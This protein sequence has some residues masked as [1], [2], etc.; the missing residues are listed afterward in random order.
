M[1]RLDATFEGLKL[2]TLDHLSDDILD[3]E[4][5]DH[6]EY[7]D[8]QIYV[9]EGNDHGGVAFVND[10]TS[11]DHGKIL[12][13]GIQPRED[14]PNEREA[15]F[16]HASRCHHITWDSYVDGDI[17]NEVSGRHVGES[18]LT[19]VF[20]PLEAA[21]MAIWAQKNI[22]FRYSAPLH[23]VEPPETWGQEDYD[24]FTEEL[25]DLSMM[26]DA[27]LPPGAALEVAEGVSEFDPE[28][29]TD[30]L[31]KSMCA[32][33]VF[34]QSILQGTQTGTVSGSETDLKSYFNNVNTE[35]RSQF[36]EPLKRDVV[37]RVARYD[38][39]T[40]PPIAANG[41]WELDWGPMFKVTDIEKAEGA[42]S[43]ITAATN[44]IKNY[45]LTP[46]EARALVA[47]EW[48]TFD[49]DV[50]LDELSEE[51]WDSLDRINIRETGRGPQDDEPVGG[52]G[53]TRENPN[54]QNGGGQPA[55]ETRE[56]SQP[57]RDDIEREALVEHI[58]QEV[59]GD[60]GEAEDIVAD[61]FEDHQPSESDEG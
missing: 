2:W 15:Y 23:A 39:D 35:I 37:E 24:N 13:Y 29:Y 57:T 60:Y 30:S 28:P 44:G 40:M 14:S 22:L 41:N 59:T 38:Q 6:T 48:T 43:L 26:S 17:G 12:G 21:M 10:I 54:L 45:V 25:E 58:D 1:S 8:D 9:T 5:E 4:V 31:V 51:Q 36:L 34:T 20:Q 56:S 50:D 19:P 32:G 52:E 49:I 18:V 53:S 11:P 33:T 47:E 55:G 46:D 42:V 27:V 16:V 7:D 3:A 61:F